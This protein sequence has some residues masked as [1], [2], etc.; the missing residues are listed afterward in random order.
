M[1]DVRGDGG[2]DVAVAELRERLLLPRV[3]LTAVDGEFGH[4]VGV[5]GGVGEPAAGADLGELVV[6]AGE[7]NA[8]TGGEVVADDVGEGADVGHTGLVDHQ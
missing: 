6:V 7:Q 2:G 3:A 8:T 5:V 1:F 4:R